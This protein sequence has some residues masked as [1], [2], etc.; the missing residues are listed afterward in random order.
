LI[1]GGALAAVAGA[2]VG[3]GRLGA[4]G[5]AAPADLGVVDGRLPPPSTTANSVSSQAAL[6]PGHPQRNA[7][8]IDPLPAGTDGTGTLQRL[9]ALIEARG[10]ARIVEARPDY[11]RVEFRTRWL[12]FVDDAEFWHDRGNRVVQ[13][14][15][16]SRIGRRD[17]DVNRG[18]IEALRAARAADR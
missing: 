4:F 7:A 16:A 6:W 10:D 1:A 3:A 14:R 13:L 18:R 5:G 8:R 15:S 9:R 11:L 17:F 2:V 12:G